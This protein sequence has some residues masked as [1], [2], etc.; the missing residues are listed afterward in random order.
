[1]VVPG[2]GL[3]KYT[4][5]PDAEKTVLREAAR[6]ARDFGSPVIWANAG[7]LYPGCGN[8]ENNLKLKE[9]ASLG[10]VSKLIVVQEEITNTVT[11]ALS[12]RDTLKADCKAKTIVVVAERAHSPS[13]RWIYKRVFPEAKIALVVVD[14]NWNEQNI[15]LLASGN[16]RWLFINVVRHFALIVLGLNIVGRMKHPTAR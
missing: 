15:V 12:I 3:L 5:L 6:I 4:T 13:V 1:V 16:W 10:L 9:A 7:Y 11:E 8:D 2:Y 14:A